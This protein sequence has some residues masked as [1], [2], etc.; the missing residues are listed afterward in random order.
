MNGSCPDLYTFPHTYTNELGSKCRAAARKN[1]WLID[2]KNE[3]FLC[4]KCNPK[5]KKYMSK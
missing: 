5:S 2:Y 4:P 1:G 3:K